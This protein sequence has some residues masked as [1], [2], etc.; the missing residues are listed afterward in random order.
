MTAAEFWEPLK[1]AGITFFSGVPCSLLTGVLAAC[2]S[3]PELCYIPAPREDAA[4]GVASGG[5][6]AGREGGILL[7]NSGL[8]NIV[9]GLSSFNLLYRVPLF[10]IISWR[11]Y[12]GKDA[13]EHRIMGAK[14]LD[15]LGLLEIPTDVL[16]AS[17]AKEQITRLI[18]SMRQRRTP[19]ALI[20]R[21]GI[22]D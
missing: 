3:D 7:Q 8:G 17:A 14:M 5:Y 20:I 19:V 22:V 1:R 13:P 15:L 11:G 9:N 4:L 6:L 2:A 12:Q 21:P 16:E 10:M 18:V